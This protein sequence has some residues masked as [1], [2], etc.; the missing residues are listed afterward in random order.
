M[1]FTAGLKATSST[2]VGIKGLSTRVDFSFNVTELQESAIDQIQ[3]RVERLNGKQNT[4]VINIRKG[5]VSVV[6]GNTRDTD[7]CTTTQIYVDLELNTKGNI[8]KG[9]FNQYTPKE[10]KKFYHEG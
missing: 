5:H 7:F 2:T 9:F 4:S 1:K 3:F 8:V 10:T 6:I